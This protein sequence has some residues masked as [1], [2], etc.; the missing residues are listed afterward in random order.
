[1]FRPF[2]LAMGLLWAEIASPGAEIEGTVT[3]TRRLTRQ[4]VTAP[5]STY[6]R[7]VATPLEV[8]EKP[9]FVAA[10]MD[11]VAIFLEGGR[12]VPTAPGKGQTVELV[13]RNRRF[14][15]DTIVIPAG[16]TVSFPNY[17]P[18]FHNVF[19]LSSAKSFDLGNYPQNQTRTVQFSKPG[20][21]PVF[22]RLHPNMSAT[23]VVA[24][25]RWVTK[26]DA[27]GRYRLNDVPPGKYTVVTW[28]K[29]A[30]A[31]RQ[32]VTIP[33]SGLTTVDFIIPLDPQNWARQGP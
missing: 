20:I 18:I 13:Q 23:V 12:A 3:V 32:T 17:D 8:E 24:P 22:C 9:D 25:G 27:Q 11:R 21:V 15:H 2:Y 6:D 16:A 28:H 4:R 7:G 19:S 5:V 26:P 14:V 30:G 29:S 33:E 1:M 31:F 10:E